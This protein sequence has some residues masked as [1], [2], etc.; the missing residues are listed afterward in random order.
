MVI[1]NYL[2]ASPAIFFFLL[3][4]RYLRHMKAMMRT[5][6]RK[7]EEMPSATSMTAS[8]RIVICLLLVPGRERSLC[9]RDIGTSDY[10][11]LNYS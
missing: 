7:T 9:V 5:V 11:F 4:L 1:S 10:P 8:S 3:S 6:T 2:N